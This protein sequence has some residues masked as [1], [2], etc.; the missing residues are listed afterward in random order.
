VSSLLV[1]IDVLYEGCVT[2]PQRWHDQAFA[3]WAEGVSASYD[4]D[5]VSARLIR[6]ALT[7]ARKLA[8][9]WL[10]H[11]DVG[12]TEDWRSRVDRALGPRAWR[13]QLDLAEHLLATDPDPDVFAV[14]ADLFP[15]VR[16][17]PYLD[18]IGYE[19]WLE[20]RAML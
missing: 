1:E 2:N 20:G 15:V 3:D 12:G 7:M 11:A 8:T 9:F 5:R 13:P 14:V 17:Q 19:A 18:G 4:L 10:D 6:R 16:N